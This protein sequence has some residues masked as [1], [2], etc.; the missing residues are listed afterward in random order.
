MNRNPTNYFAE[1][2]QLAFAPA[3]MIPG[4]E[5]SPDK[6]LQGRLFSYVDTQRHRVGANFPQLPVN[7]PLASLVSY[8]RDGPMSYDNQGAAPNYFPNSVNGPIVDD[9]AAQ[10]IFHLSGNV[11]RYNS[12]DE[13]NFSQ[14]DLFWTT[15]LT[16]VERQ[17]LVDNIA[18]HLRNARQDIIT[19]A[20]ANFAA[21]NVQ[22]GQ[23]LE[24]ALQ[25][26]GIKAGGT[27]RARRPAGGPPVGYA[28]VKSPV[29]GGKRKRQNH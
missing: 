10:S 2:E 4:I 3:N 14:V 12:A 24:E 28:S 8:T 20:V 16:P 23:M 21:V 6:M 9:V 25:G 26:Y 17:R 22:F 5:A 1:V 18:G 27:R 29:G 13:D 11:N 7:K 15:V 19:R